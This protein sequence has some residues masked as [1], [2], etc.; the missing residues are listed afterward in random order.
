MMTRFQ[1][2]YWFVNR[3]GYEAPEEPTPPPTTRRRRRRRNSEDC[4]ID[5][6][7][8]DDE[9]VGGQGRRP[10]K[11]RK[12]YLPVMSIIDFDLQCMLSITMSVV[13]AKV[14][15]KFLKI[16]CQQVF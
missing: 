8:S 9:Y 6:F 7:S 13:H 16:T 11:V 5:Q 12:S 15:P 10:K 3:F 14:K 2:F 4:N 1:F